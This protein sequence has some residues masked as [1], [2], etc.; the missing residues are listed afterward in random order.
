MSWCSRMVREQCA[1]G[2]RWQQRHG[3]TGTRQRRQYSHREKSA[4]IHI[5]KCVAASEASTKLISKHVVLESDA[6]IPIYVLGVDHLARQFDLGL[7][8][9]ARDGLCRSLAEGSRDVPCGTA[10]S[11]LPQS[12]LHY[13]YPVSD[14]IYCPYPIHPY[15]CLDRVQRP[16]EKAPQAPPAHPRTGHG[17]SVG[18]PE[19]DSPSSMHVSV[20]LFCVSRIWPIRITAIRCP[21]GNVLVVALIAWLPV[22]LATSQSC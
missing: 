10:G 3:A 11:E 4:S 14:Q 13:T 15:P 1:R 18:I 21:D 20:Q 8:F 12:A 19:R 5:G 17:G 2:W 7:P 22:W 6:G 9:A 16:A